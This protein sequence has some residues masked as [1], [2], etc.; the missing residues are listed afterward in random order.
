MKIK[1]IYIRDEN[2]PHYDP[3]II[4]YQNEIEYVISQIRVILGTQNG[5]VLGDYNFG[6]DLDYMVFNTKS[7]SKEV[8]SKL[9]DQINTYVNHSD[10]VSIYCDINFGDSGLGYDYA[11]LDIYI[12]GTK[13]IGFLIDKNDN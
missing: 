11:V 1:E 8:M 10:Q 3:T 7:S 4:D 5:Q 2:D 9:N 12:N 6:I 13:S